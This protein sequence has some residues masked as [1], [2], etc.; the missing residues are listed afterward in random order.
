MTGSLRIQTTGC[1]SQP[2]L[3][4]AMGGVWASDKAAV[5]Q[6]LE[7]QPC[8]RKGCAA[9]VLWLWACWEQLLVLDTSVLLPLDLHSFI[10]L[11]K[12]DS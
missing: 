3:P 5:C 7:P 2:Q 1:L 6:G 11:E 4:G 9:R 12:A 10:A 8:P